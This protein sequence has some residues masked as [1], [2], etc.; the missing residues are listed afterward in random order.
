MRIFPAIDIL[1]QRCVRLKQ[2]NYNE[3]TTY[4]DPVEMAQEWVDEGASFLHL[5]DLDAA[6]GDPSENLDVIRQI[7]DT[8]SIPVQVG[9][10]V[11]SLERIEELIEIG[12]NRV[13]LG[14]AAVKNPDFVKAAVDQ[15]G[16][17]RIV[18]SVDAR[19]GYVATDGW[20]ETSDIE[21]S[22]FAKQLESAG[23]KTIVYTDISKDGM[24]EGPNFEALSD[25]N[26]QSE[27]QIIA[28]GGVSSL[29]DIQRLSELNLYG[30]IVGK[31][32]Y[33]DRVNL[34]DIMKEPKTC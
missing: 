13:I 33:E 3:Q 12:V 5:V 6:K 16:E 27:L 9:G 8:V 1:N 24:L 31:A 11:R 17:E 25:L 22:Q 34:S 21:A 2:G 29:S 32:L 15:F 23:V 26:E 20:I 4:G 18:V 7:V 19:D 10:G 30:A 28:S 14:T